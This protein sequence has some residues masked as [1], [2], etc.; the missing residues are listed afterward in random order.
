MRKK[1]VW[2]FS[3]HYIRLPHQSPGSKCNPEALQQRRKDLLW[4]LRGLLCQTAS[5]HRYEH[6][7][8][9]IEMTW[10]VHWTATRVQMH[11]Y[12]VDWR[13]N[14]FRFH[15]TCNPPR[16][17]LWSV[18]TFCSTRRANLSRLVCEISF[19]EIVTLQ[20]CECLLF[21]LQITSNGEIP[22]TRDLSTSS[23]MM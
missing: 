2:H 16:C 9:L 13:W 14:C 5:S 8:C 20:C 7:T 17:Y 12:I 10:H 6:R 4:W 18:V 19:I 3:P 22:C 11:A 15:P 21:L 23:T 1:S